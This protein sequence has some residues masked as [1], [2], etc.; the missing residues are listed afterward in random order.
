MAVLPIAKLGNPI[1]RQQATPI[2]TRDIRTKEFQQLID[3]MFETMLDEPGIGLAAPQISRSIQLV[4]MGCEGEGGF[5]QTTLINPKIVYYGPQQVENWEGCLSVDGL[6]GKV[7]RP[8]V[9]RVQALNR[10]GRPVDIEADALYSVCI[11]H[12]MDHLIGKLFVDRMTDMST[13]TQLPEFEKYWRKEP[14]PVI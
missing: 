5:P 4:V 3:D 10:D 1:L 11:Q 13:L 2:D 8:S 14:T 7:I 12:E 9:I 6:R